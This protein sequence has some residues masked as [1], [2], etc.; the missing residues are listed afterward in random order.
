MQKVDQYYNNKNS[1]QSASH[2]VPTCLK[3]KKQQIDTDLGTYCNNLSIIE[4]ICFVL[5][6]LF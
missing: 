2:Y 4:T 3:T 5:E 6:M 1:E